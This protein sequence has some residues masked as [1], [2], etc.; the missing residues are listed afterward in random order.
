MYLRRELRRVQCELGGLRSDHER[1]EAAR[2]KSTYESL[3]LVWCGG[4]E[5]ARMPE[6][7]RS[8]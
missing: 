7:S 8:D 4:P 2:W 6:L 5:N 3:R 1:E